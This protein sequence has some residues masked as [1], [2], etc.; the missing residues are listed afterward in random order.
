M[1]EVTGPAA[2]GAVP[3]LEWTT[4][5][6]TVEAALDVVGD[7]AT[8][9]VVRE[10]GCGVRRFADMQRRT[11][12]PRDV[13]ARR[14]A[15]MVDDGLL[16][17][18]PY[19]EPGRR[20]REEYRFT[21]KGFDLYPVVVAL[22]RW[23]SRWTGDAGAVQPPIE[24]AHRGCGELVHAEVRCAAGHEVR[25]PRDVLPRPGPGAVRAVSEPP[26]GPVDGPVEERRRARR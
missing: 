19:R 24:F 23:G 8:F 3:A 14:L 1:S 13:L 2:A 10:V 4:E 15:R 18:V 21:D 6:C 22:W 12:L 9:M 16:R 7:R 11:G 20:A 17:R 25:E 26:D 5:G